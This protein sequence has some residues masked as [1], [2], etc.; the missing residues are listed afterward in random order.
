MTWAASQAA[1]LRRVVVEGDLSLFQVIDHLT[2]S[3]SG[4]YISDS[5]VTGTIASGSQQ[6][7]FLRN[8]DIEAWKGGVWNMV[9]VGVENAPSGH[10]GKDKDKGL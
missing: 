10:C 1:P 2:G 9:F 3:S 7:Y 6:Q 8:T 4:G 5:T